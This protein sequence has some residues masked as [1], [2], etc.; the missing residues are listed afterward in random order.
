MRFGNVEYL[1]LWLL[2]P[3]LVAFFMW[4][5]QRRQR[6]LRRFADMRLVKKLT[7]GARVERQAAKWLLFIG[8]FVS[9]VFVLARPRFG[10][11]TEMVERRGVDVMVA[12]DISKSMLAR[13]IVPN[14]LDRAKHE[15]DRFIDLLKG[16]RVG[17]IVFAGESFVQCPLTLDYG[18]AKM[19]LDAV[20]SDW[21]SLQGTALADAI[22]QSTKAFESLKRKHKVLVLLSDGEDHE[23]DAIAAAREAAKEGVRIYTVGIGSEKGVPIPI[24]KGKGTVIYKK[25]RNGN[26]VMTRLNPVILE[27][28]ALEANGSYFNAGTNLD[29]KRIYTEIA[30][31]EKRDFGMNKMSVYEERYQVFLLFALALLLLEFFLP[32]RVKRKEEWR[33][34]FE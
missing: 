29:L 3:A 20:D 19:F 1:W 8:F 28:I 2:T 9:I 10:I 12:L 4:A 14:R 5:Y 23:G 24:S 32:E 30:R 33:G 22:R 17:L 26:L 6:T 18:A 27:K 16:D 25:D 34:R 21:I 11:K 31:M 13:D 15:I 7:P